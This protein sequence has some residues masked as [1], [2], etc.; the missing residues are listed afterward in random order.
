MTPFRALAEPIADMLRPITYPELF[1]PEEHPVGDG[2]IP[3]AY[4]RTLMLDH[5]DREVAADILER[6]EAH[7]RVPGTM[8]S[9]AQL[10]V[11][12]GACAR[13]PADAT[14]YA[15]RSSRIMGN[16]A[17][18]YSPEADASVQRGWV[19][20]T[21]DALRQSDTGSYVNFLADEGADGV[22]SAYPEP[23]LSRL[24]DIK[25]RYDPNNLFHRN[26]N[27]RPEA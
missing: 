17:A 21:I 11:L 4:G 27:I 18:V 1:P 25:R 16:I 19:S 2:P 5:V 9:V 14:A 12:G 15:H 8:F 26:Q 10:R 20:T 3:V 6:V 7:A 24:R 22:R 23:T 13:V